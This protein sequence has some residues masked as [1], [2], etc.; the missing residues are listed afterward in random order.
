[1]AVNTRLPFIIFILPSQAPYEHIQEEDCLMSPAGTNVRRN[2][3][4][5]MSLLCYLLCAMRYLM[6]QPAKSN[7]ANPAST[8]R[9]ARIDGG[10]GE[11]ESSV[12]ELCSLESVCGQA[13]IYRHIAR[14][15]FT[16]TLTRHSKC[17]NIDRDFWLCANIPYRHNHLSGACH[18][19]QN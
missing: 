6:Y 17:L 19:W 13:C 5:R 8:R 4:T 12:P 10:G 7:T 11:K 14:C 3:A 2:R 18:Y 16:T 1:M 15:V 9:Q